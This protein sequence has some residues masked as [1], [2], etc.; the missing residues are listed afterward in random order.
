MTNTRQVH[1]ITTTA[2]KSVSDGGRVSIYPTS[3][4]GLDCL[5]GIVI[6]PTSTP[7][8][9]DPLVIFDHSAPPILQS[10][11]S[12]TSTLSPRMDDPLTLAQNTPSASDHHT[13][14]ITPTV[15]PVAPS[16]APADDPVIASSSD[17]PDDPVVP[18]SAPA[19]EASPRLPSAHL[20][21][22]HFAKR[23]RLSPSN[24]DALGVP[25][26][27]GTPAATLPHQPLSLPLLSSSPIQQQF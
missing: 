2:I 11:H 20:D 8:I 25:A 22:N 15:D 18:S 4:Q 21:P 9:E 13:P 23:Q 10:R 16:S 19:I 12:N 17:P 3:V 27:S 6:P 24:S 1:I 7:S 26:L 14:S 5:Q